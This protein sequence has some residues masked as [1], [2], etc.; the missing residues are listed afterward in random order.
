MGRRRLGRRLGGG[1]WGGGYGYGGGWGGPGFGGGGWASP[2]YGNWYRGGWGGSGFWTGY[3]LGAM[4]T[5]GLGALG[6]VLSYPGYS[7]S[8]MIGYPVA[9]YGLYDYFPTWGVSNYASWGLGTMA[10]SALYSNYTNPYYTQVVAAQ[11]V[12]TTVVF[13]YSQP[14]NVAATPPDAAVANSTEQVFSAARDAFKAGDYA[15]ALA[16]ADQVIQQ[17]P[18]VP[19]VHEFRGLGA[20]SPWGDTT[21]RHRPSTRSSRPSRAGTG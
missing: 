19:V 10:S 8:S 9:S 17:T 13:D 15:R 14:I 1:G 11:P 6:S 5:F 20:C 7:Y 21:R 2:Y 16:Q 18:N 12:Q 3:G 4:T